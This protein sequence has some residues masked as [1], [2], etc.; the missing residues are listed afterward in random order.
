MGAI[1][2]FHSLTTPERPADGDAHVPLAF[3]KSAV[4]IARFLGEIVSLDTLVRRH[5]AGT[6]TSGLIALTFDDAYAALGGECAEFIAAEDVPVTVFVTTDATGGGRPF[7]WDRVDDSFRRVAPSTWRSFEQACGLPEEYRRQQPADFGPL[8]PLRQWI[9]ARHAGRWPAAL[10]PA[11]EALEADAGVRT[12]H[13]AMTF[14]E[15]DALAR[16]PTVDLGVHTVSHPVL[17]LLG[18]EDLRREIVQCYA[19]LRHRFARALPIL[20]VPFALYDRRT[21]DIARAAGMTA[22]LSLSGTTVRDGAAAGALPRLC[23]TRQD[24]LPRLAFRMAGLRDAISAWRGRHP[25]AYP[26]LPSAAT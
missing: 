4:R 16:I 7:W 24:T 9:L 12:R 14:S 15:L 20:A 3:F 8:R 13:R 18:D 17:P 6:S 23:I 26:D 5:R 22:S 25:A 1:L 19:T 2:C 21:I 11:L 10:E